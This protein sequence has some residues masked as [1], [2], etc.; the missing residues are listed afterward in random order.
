[1]LWWSTTVALLPRMEP[2]PRP[3]PRP[4]PVVAAP[5]PAVRVYVTVTSVS[6]FSGKALMCSMKV[7]EAS[8][9]LV[10]LGGLSSDSDQVCTLVVNVF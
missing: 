7:R 2:P 6:R 3:A 1:M 9:D 8:G 10:G 4:P 5:P